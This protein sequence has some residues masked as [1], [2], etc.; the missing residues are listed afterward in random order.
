MGKISGNF[1][2][3]AYTSSEQRTNTKGD[4]NSHREGDP[5]NREKNDTPAGK[6]EQIK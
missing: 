5:A 3:I 1:F 4:L 2:R 6:G